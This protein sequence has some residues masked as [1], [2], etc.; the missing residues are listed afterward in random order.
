[1]VRLPTIWL[2]W[3]VFG[4]FATASTQLST[5]LQF[6]SPLQNRSFARYDLKPTV[7]A[8]SAGDNKNPHAVRFPLYNN[9]VQILLEQIGDAGPS[10]KP[11]QV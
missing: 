8:V 2:G 1:M 10:G 9:S 5:S 3:V 6:A 7:N 11:N 4:T